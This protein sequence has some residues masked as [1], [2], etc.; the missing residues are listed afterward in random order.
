MAQINNF[1]ELNIWKES[2]ALVDLIYKLTRQ[3][4]FSKDFQFIDHIRK[5]AISIPSNISEGF[6]RDGTKEFVNFLSIAKGS[7]GELRSQLFIAL[8][9]KYLD[10]EQFDNINSKVLEISKSISAL[11]KYL[12]NCAYKGRK[13][14]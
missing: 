4:T 1:E 3:P 2:R 8:D 6:E 9:Q 7:C 14:K 13:F 12:Q 5:T 11:M 10:Q